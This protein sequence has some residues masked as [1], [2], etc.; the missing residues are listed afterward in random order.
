MS[1]GVAER[2]GGTRRVSGA[3]QLGIGKRRTRVGAAQRLGRA[4]QLGSP[5]QPSRVEPVRGSERLPRLPPECL[6]LMNGFA[7][8]LQTILPGVKVTP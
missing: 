8:G 2:L 3:R 4:R 1:I 5:G 7:A 6:G